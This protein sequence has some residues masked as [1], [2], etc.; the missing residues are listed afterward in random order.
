[1]SGSRTEMLSWGDWIFV[2][3]HKSGTT[4]G[5]IIARA[6][7]L[8]SGRTFYKYKYR[9]RVRNQLLGE[10]GVCHFLVKVCARGPMPQFVNDCTLSDF[11]TIARRPILSLSH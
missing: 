5:S 3:H 2:G 7:C 8:G 1:M 6:L 10:T 11:S 4:V 9:E